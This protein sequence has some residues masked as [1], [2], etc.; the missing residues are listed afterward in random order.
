MPSKHDI[1]LILAYVVVAILCLLGWVVIPLI[2]AL[3]GVG[4]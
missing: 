2:G 1:L 3:K 4:V